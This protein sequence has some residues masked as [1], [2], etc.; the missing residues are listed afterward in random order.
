MASRI[1]AAA[2]ASALN[3]HSQNDEILF[4]GIAYFDREWPF[5]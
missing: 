5:A 4:T 3:N 1:S 2:V